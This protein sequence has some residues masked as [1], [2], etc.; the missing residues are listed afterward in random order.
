[1]G[2]GKSGR[3]KSTGRTKQGEQAMKRNRDELNIK[4]QLT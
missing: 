1:M 2:A 4:I 3:D